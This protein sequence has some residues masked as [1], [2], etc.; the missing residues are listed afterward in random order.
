MCAN[1]KIFEKHISL[2][3]KF[4][5]SFIFDITRYRRD[6]PESLDADLPCGL[7]EFKSPIKLY[8]FVPLLIRSFH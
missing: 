2:V 8:F 6:N 4:E 5:K 7:L 3:R 1:V